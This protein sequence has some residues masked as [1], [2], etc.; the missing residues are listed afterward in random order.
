MALNCS[1]PTFPVVVAAPLVCLSLKLSS[2]SILETVGHNIVYNY[3]MLTL[4]APFR[5][6][7]SSVDKMSTV[8]HVASTHNSICRITVHKNE[9]EA[10][11]TT[12]PAKG[13]ARAIGTSC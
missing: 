2:V 9:E 3:R 12:C 11:D 10:S 4:I 5:S 6:L 13:P 8:A 1:I 7:C